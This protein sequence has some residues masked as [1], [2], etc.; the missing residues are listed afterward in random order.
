MIM[1]IAKR[2]HRGESRPAVLTL[3]PTAFV[4]A[5]LSDRAFWAA[6]LEGAEE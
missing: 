4:C 6:G 3:G 5:K 2:S 1:A